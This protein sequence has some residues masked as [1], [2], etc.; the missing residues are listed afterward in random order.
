MNRNVNSEEGLHSCGYHDGK[1]ATQPAQ[2][3]PSEWAAIKA[4]LDEYGLQA[5]DFVA[6]FKAALAQPKHLT[7]KE[8]ISREMTAEIAAARALA[9]P[10]QESLEDL[11]GALHRIDTVAV[12]LPTFEVRHEGGLDAFV[13]NIVDAI[14]ALHEQRKPLTD[15]RE[16]VGLT[17]DEIKDIIGSWGDT[18]I[19]G[20]TRKLFDQIEAKLRRKN[21]G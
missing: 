1:R 18:P 5:I 7:E 3:P 13:Q 19:K 8:K 6:N 21:N 17:D 16:W 2:E 15:E 11:R 12:G 20:Y 14:V 4:I 10:A 9:Q